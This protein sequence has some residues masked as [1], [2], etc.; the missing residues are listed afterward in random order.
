MA[1]YL[2]THYSLAKNRISI[3]PNFVDTQRFS[4]ARKPISKPLRRAVLF[5][6]NGFSPDEQTSLEHACHAHGISLDKIGG[7]YGNPNPNPELDLP[8]YDIA[9]AIGRCAIEAMASGCATI[10]IVPALAGE[11]VTTTNFED[12]ANCNFSPR[13]FTTSEQVSADWLA[14]QLDAYHPEDIG[15]VTADVRARF[16][17]DRAIDDLQSLYRFAMNAPVR[18]AGKRSVARYLEMLAREADEQWESVALHEMKER[19]QE[20]RI[21]QLERAL[22]K[23]LM[24]NRTLVDYLAT[25]ADLPLDNEA[26]DW[27][28]AIALSGLF[29]P[30]WYMAQNPDVGKQDLDP[31]DHYLAHGARGGLEPA[32]GF[33]SERFYAVHPKLRDLDITPLEYLVRLAAVFDPAEAP[34]A[35]LTDDGA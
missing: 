26:A 5:G 14:R 9:F 4:R 24:R 16:S 30:D 33:D 22:E 12:W 27:K 31:L 3:I 28:N 6:Q 20:R 2:A 11:L 32:A 34:H 35:E 25:V 29:D 15:R 23:S 18:R 7:A 19:R 1:T 8:D 17:I 13:Y 21:E 10:P